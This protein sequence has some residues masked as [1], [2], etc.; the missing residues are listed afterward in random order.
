MVAPIKQGGEFFRYA[1]FAT[2]LMGSGTDTQGVF[3]A[4]M[5]RMLDLNARLGKLIE[6]APQF[7][8]NDAIAR[9]QAILD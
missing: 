8:V 2:S 6:K 5:V 3:L 9:M 4:N 7:I 1:G